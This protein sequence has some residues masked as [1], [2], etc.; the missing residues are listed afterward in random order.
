ME[1]A[2]PRDRVEARYGGLAAT[3]WPGPHPGAASPR[4]EEYSRLTDPGRYGIVHTRARLWG[5]ELA[6]LP[7]V[8]AETV[9]RGV[10]LTSSRPDTLPLLL[11]ER[12]V[13]SSR[14]G[15]PALA[16]LPLCAARPDIVLQ[17]VPDCGCDACDRGSDDLLDCIDETIGIV[18][19]GPLVIVRG[20]GWQLRWWPHGSSS[21]GT[22]RH[23]ELTDMCRR[24]AEGE[25]ITPPKGTEA[26]IG[27]SW[28]A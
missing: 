5:E 28:L 8:D 24:L 10:R 26:L 20:D 27:R 16:V 21:S 25:Q 9:E 15:V 23:V 4:E 13:A 22:D 18:V 11:M 3:S 17:A 6:A 7:G 14:A 12:D 1:A 2:D 19:D